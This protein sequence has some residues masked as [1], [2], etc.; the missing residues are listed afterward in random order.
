[1]RSVADLRYLP[2]NHFQPHSSAR[3]LILY[4]YA[5]VLSSIGIT[6]LLLRIR[7]L[8]SEKLLP[9]NNSSP[10][11]VQGDTIGLRAI[12]KK[13]PMIKG[14]RYIC[15]VEPADG[16]HRVR[17]EKGDGFSVREF[18]YTFYRASYPGRAARSAAGS[19]SPG[20]DI[21]R[22]RTR[23]E[24]SESRPV[25]QLVSAKGLQR[26]PGSLSPAPELLSQTLPLFSV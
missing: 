2:V 19:S 15:M 20:L 16:S 11:H 5:P 1:M 22:R 18:S 24:A 6:I 23:P 4:G 9:L 17:Q 26:A 7:R 12:D 25:A 8:C 3:I 14:W 10:V 21:L 13:N